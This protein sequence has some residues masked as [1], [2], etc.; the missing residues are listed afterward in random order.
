L[1]RYVRELYL[2]AATSSQNRSEL[3]IVWHQISQKKTLVCGV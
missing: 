3:S 2:I 1:N